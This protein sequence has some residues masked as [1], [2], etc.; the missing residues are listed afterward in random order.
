MIKGENVCLAVL[1]RHLIPQ[2]QRNHCKTTYPN[3]RG[4]REREREEGE[5]EGKC[6]A[7]SCTIFS[8]CPLQRFIETPTNA[9]IHSP[10][11]EQPGKVPN[12]RPRARAR[13]RPSHGHANGRL[14]AVALIINTLSAVLLMMTASPSLTLAEIP[15]KGKCFNNLMSSSPW[16]SFR[17]ID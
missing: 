17:L 2:H 8:Y 9:L 15:S 14:A 13:P 7:F 10:S 4:R 11:Q 3:A 1:L 12:M 6:L 16:A 5:G